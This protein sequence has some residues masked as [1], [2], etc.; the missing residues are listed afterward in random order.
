MLHLLVIGDVGAYLQ[1]IKNLKNL[2][3]LKNISFC[4]NIQSALDLINQQKIDIVI[5]DVKLD[6]E[7][8]MKDL[9]SKLLEIPVFGYSLDIDRKNAVKAIKAGVSDYISID[10]EECL[11]AIIRSC[12]ERGVELSSA[13]S[14]MRSI[15]DMISRIAPS[16]ANI[17]L[18][19]ESGTGK[20]VVAQYI[21]IKSSRKDRDLISVNCAAIPDNLLES[22]LFGYEKG[23]FT[24]ALS[25]KKG[26]FEQADK[27][28]LLLDEISEMDMRLQAK[29][30]RAIQEKKIDRLGS[31]FPISVDIRIIA[32]SNRDLKKEV[33]LGNFR[34]DLFFR[35]NV[36]NINLPPLRERKEDIAFLAREFVKKYSEINNLKEKSVS[37]SLIAKFNE[38][39][40]PG[41]IREL[42]NMMYRGVLLSND[43]EISEK[44]VLP[45]DENN[46]EKSQ[47]YGDFVGETINFMEKKLI[48]NTISHCKGN[49]TKAADIL[50]ISIRTLR[51]KLN[52]YKEEKEFE[53]S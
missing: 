13:S 14:N 34:Q 39:S 32:T 12:E 5:I 22:E 30:L 33:E 38:Y 48:S 43:S 52:N 26:K 11:I 7:S 9:N 47:N 28:T 37:D 15:I 41:N 19:G 51:N 45:F 49:K 2:N 16:Q 25:T 21:H 27:S 44:D 17:L 8:F 31:T 35:L 6:I 53:E 50:G 40:W 23:A 20:E 4:E 1:N 10:D 24:G 46:F 3:I 36:I 29:L 42:E 18:T